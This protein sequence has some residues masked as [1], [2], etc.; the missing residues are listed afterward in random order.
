VS[1]RICLLGP[2]RIERD[3]QVELPRGRKAWGLLAYLTQARTPVPRE[4]LG[5]LLFPEADDPLAALRWSLTELRRVLGERAVVEGD[6]LRLVLPAASFVDVDV[7]T[8]GTWVEAVRLPGVGQDLLGGITF[9]H[10]PGF[11]LW[12]DGERR[13]LSAAAEAALH[14]AALA[15]LARDEAARAADYA[16]QL[17]GLN[18][19]DEN[20]QTLLVRCLSIGGDVE[21][22]ERQA[23]ACAELYR[24]ELGVEPTPALRAAVRRPAP[25]AGVYGRA[26]T[27]A[28]IEAGESAVAAGALEPGLDALRRAMAAARRSHHRDLLARALVSLGSS[29]VHAARGSDEEGAAALHEGI[30]LAEA[31]DDPVLAA[32]A[33]REIGW[34]DLL[35]ARY[36]QADK[37][38][39]TA[40][41]LAAGDDGELAWIDLIRGAH[42][43][44]V[45][46]YASA[47]DYL[48][49]AIKRADVVGADRPGA[50]ARAVQGRLHL[51]RG[52]L[53]DARTMLDAARERVTA[54]GWTTFLPYPESYRAEVDLLAGD[55]DAAAEGFEHAFSLGCQVGDPCWEGLGCRGLGLVAAARGDLPRAFELLDEAPRRCRRLPDTYLWVE[56]YCQEALCAVGVEHGA[57]S[58]GRWID[59]LD[60]MASRHGM[61]ELLARATIHRARLGEPG[62]LEAARSRAA[63][64]DNPALA[65]LIASLQ[66]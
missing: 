66:A 4:R 38:L 2:P 28:Q 13:H 43:S 19:F 59:E 65:D 12:L 42:R 14:E 5:G 64:V 45:G 27:T 58:T 53:D 35:R 25:S 37:A 20:Y 33:W 49:V 61:R 40:A 26:T 31:L 24:S 39:G 62:A 30:A 48:Q 15:C 6:P 3:G 50:F 21:G 11:Q 17:V 36:S 32:T 29:L 60:T 18:P 7:L 34:V 63:D 9:P 44:D 10:S 47:A 55:H 16:G 56:A 52:E 41:D 23:E 8:R 22:A 1:L 51:L 46:D 54:I 57:A